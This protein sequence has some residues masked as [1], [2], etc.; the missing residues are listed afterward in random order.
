MLSACPPQLWLDASSLESYPGKQETMKVSM[1]WFKKPQG[2]VVQVQMWPGGYKTYSYMWQGRPLLRPSEIVIVP[3][4]NLPGIGHAARVMRLGQSPDYRGP[5]KT[6]IRKATEAD[7][8]TNQEW[9]VLR[10]IA[11]GE[12]T[13]S[14]RRM[15][16]VIPGYLIA[17]GLA[18]KDSSGLVLTL[19]GQRVAHQERINLDEAWKW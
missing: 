15:K 19:Y 10:E 9:T 12:V 7:S 11:Q 18:E 3:S 4:P 8:L 14:S 5:L 1:S 16:Q 17:K 13:F 6:V 2:Q